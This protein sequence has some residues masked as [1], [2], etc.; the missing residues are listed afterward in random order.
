MNRQRVLISGITGFL[1][2]QLAR[3][4]LVNQN[5]DVVGIHR[6]N[7]DFSRLADIA[8]RIALY[9]I[10]EHEI[11]TVLEKERLNVLVNCVAEYGHNR[12]AIDILNANLLLPLRILE[13]A[14]NHG[15]K[16]FINAGTTLPADVNA[17]ALSKH[18]FSQW[19]RKLSSN[20]VAVDFQIEH[21]YG[22]GESPARFI[23][24]VIEKLMRPAAELDLTKGEQKRD[25][26][27]VADVVRAIVL[28]VNLGNQ[29]NC[30]Y[31]QFP[32]GSGQS[33][34]L[35]DV[36]EQIRLLT[37][38]NFTRINYG[39]IPY[40]DSEVMESKADIRKLRELGWK[41]CIALDDG[42]RQSID[43]YRQRQKQR[44]VG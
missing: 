4:L 16:V 37:K 12:A 34:L 29:W 17:Y 36:V 32:I 43:L 42:L 15:V 25:F 35:K 9:N 11:E 14:S 39:A 31:F 41:P 1:G 5:C 22:P 26:V 24:F 27:H 20:I 44:M 18:Q 21:F 23:T 38:N 19:M 30:G 8:D 7:S 6:S 10:E 28:I 2:S 3:E 33:Y 40:R 13:S